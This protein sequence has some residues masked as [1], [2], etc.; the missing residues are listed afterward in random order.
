MEFKWSEAVKAIANVRVEDG[1]RAA[2]QYREKSACI[3]GYPTNNCMHNRHIILEMNR[4]IILLKA[5]IV[6]LNKSEAKHPIRA[7]VCQKCN[8][9][10]LEND[11]VCL[12]LAPFANY[13]LPIIRNNHWTTFSCLQR[14]VPPS[15]V[16]WVSRR[17]M[18]P[19]LHI[20]QVRVASVC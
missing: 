13:R 14:P 7:R 11:A 1:T 18:C 9:N 3:V 8:L 17:F 6:S 4:H 10:R 15:V 5:V 16:Q 19:L 12:L 2:E 20:L